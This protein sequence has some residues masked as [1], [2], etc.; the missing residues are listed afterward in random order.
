[1]HGGQRGMDNSTD[2]LTDKSTIIDVLTTFPCVWNSSSE[3][4][5][6]VSA[7]LIVYLCLKN[8]Y[9]KRIV[10]Y[11]TYRLLI[12]GVGVF[13]SGGKVKRNEE[14]GGEKLKVERIEHYCIINDTCTFFCWW[15]AGG[16]WQE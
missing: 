4:S 7:H 14:R 5:E 6:S 15:W 1:M 16:S 11:N 13:K 8:T 10:Q 3:S 9:R 2:K 12:L